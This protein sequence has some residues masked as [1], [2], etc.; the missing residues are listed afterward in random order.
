MDQASNTLP[1]SALLCRFPRSDHSRAP[2]SQLLGGSSAQPWFFFVH[3][4]YA[5]SWLPVIHDSSGNRKRSGPRWWAWTAA[6]IFLPVKCFSFTQGSFH[7]A[8]CS[9]CWPWLWVSVKLEQ[10]RMAT[11]Q[12]DQADIR[13]KTNVKVPSSTMR[14][15]KAWSP[16]DG[17]YWTHLRGSFS[18]CP[19][20]SARTT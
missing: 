15:T 14:P 6:T 11:V 19:A 2:S 3:T 1:C 17:G 12:A 13:A 5:S 18:R 7:G 16:A 9:W 20:A 10:W 4:P 8:Q